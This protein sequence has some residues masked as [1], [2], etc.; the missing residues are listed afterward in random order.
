MVSHG[1]TC[2]AGH[3]ALPNLGVSLHAEPMRKRTV[4]LLLLGELD[5][6]AEG[7]VGRLYIEHPIL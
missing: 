5:L 1:D 2:H 6:G 7:L 4:L 3:W